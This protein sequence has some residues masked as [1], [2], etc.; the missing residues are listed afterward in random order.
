M[1]EEVAFNEDW[2]KEEEKMRK[3]RTGSP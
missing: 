2:D 3:I 1:R